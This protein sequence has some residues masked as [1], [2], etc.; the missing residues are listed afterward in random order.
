MVN[1][2][3]KWPVKNKMTKKSKNFEAPKFVW[4]PK[5]SKQ[6]KRQFL[7]KV[8]LRKE[9][10]LCT[11]SENIPYRTFVLNRKIFQEEFRPLY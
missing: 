7:K 11:K 4:E 8:V 2:K 1:A 10:D 9:E 6:C 3:A 5:Y